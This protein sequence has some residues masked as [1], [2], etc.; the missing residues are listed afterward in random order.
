MDTLLGVSAVFIPPDWNALLALF[1]ILLFVLFVAWFAFT[2]RKFAT[3]GPTRRAPARIEPITP[4]HVHMPGGSAAPIAVAFGAGFLFAGL[5]VGGVGLVI[6]VTILV[7][8]LPIWFR[9]AVRDYRHLEPAG[10][11]VQRLP[12]VVHEGPPPGVHMPGPSIR[13]LMGA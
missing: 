8:T 3:L 9:E 2:A 6:G 5:V 12:A 1:P 11:A 7:I 10:T 4:A 13:P